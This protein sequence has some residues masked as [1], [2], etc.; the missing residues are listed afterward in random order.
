[1]SGRKGSIGVDAPH[2]HPWRGAETPTK[3]MKATLEGSMVNDVADVEESPVR[4]GGWAPLVVGVGVLLAVLMIGGG[5]L[6]A[7][8]LSSPK[9][10]GV[11]PAA[12]ASAGSDKAAKA[13][14]F[15][16]C[17]RKNGVPNHPDPLRTGPFSWPRRTTST[18]TRRPSRRRRAPV[19][20]PTPELSN[21]RRPAR[22]RPST[23]RST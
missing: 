23:R 12:S 20:M 14:E 5:I 15:V 7:T 19:R 2:A 6:V 3:I 11:A 10:V 13:T 4:G 9:S 1:M 17:M 21:S 18:S 22:H 8:R 16:A